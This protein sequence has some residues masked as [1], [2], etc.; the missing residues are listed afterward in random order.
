V[1]A[2]QAGKVSAAG[3]D[4]FDPEPLRP[5]HPF[6]DLPNIVLTPH[7]AVATPE[8]NDALL[9]GVS[10]NVRAWVSGAATNVVNPTVGG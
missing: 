3:L 4:V 9:H 8:A 5:D 1:A 10:A 7:A 2:L 6:R